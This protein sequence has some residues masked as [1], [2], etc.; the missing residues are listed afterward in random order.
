MANHSAHDQ[1][2]LFVQLQTLRAQNQT[3][4]TDLSSLHSKLNLLKVRARTFRLY[5]HTIF[6]TFAGI[7]AR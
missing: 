6:N 3:L 1:G 5:E 4:S 7:Q 2:D